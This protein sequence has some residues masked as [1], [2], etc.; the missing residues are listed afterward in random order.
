MEADFVTL[1][2]LQLR[3]GTRI[4]Y[5]VEGS[6]ETN[7][8]LLGGG[9]LG[10]HN[11]P[12]IVYSELAKHYRVLSF[13]QRGYGMS[14]K[15]SQAYTIDLWTDDIARVLDELKIPR[16]Y[17]IGTSVGG[18][19]A[20]RFAAKY[21]ERTIAVVADVP[22][23]RPDNMRKIMFANWRKIALVA[24]VGELFADVIIT[25]NVGA[26]YLEGA[27]AENVRKSIRE[28]LAG[29]PVETVVQVCKMME[30]LDITED[31][32]KI[33]APS[34]IMGT[35][36]DVVSPLCME[37][38]GV[39]GR[40]VA[41]M[42]PGA[43]LKVWEGIGHADMIE[44]PEQSVEYVIKFLAELEKLERDRTDSQRI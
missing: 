42:I 18:V 7:C 33:R 19:L 28:L 38:S 11:F 16:A 25:Y 36:G 3:D 23:A 4:Y 26:K 15:P 35:A 22:I 21:P 37:E 17:V 6:G 34:L 1:P 32:R 29:T 10:R 43:T 30:E 39:G 12:P 9:L 41:Q 40:K 2:K 27:G 20:L 14:D 24:G 31:L 13:D 8:V 5:E 44:I